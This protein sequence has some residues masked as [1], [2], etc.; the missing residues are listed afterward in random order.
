MTAS[1]NRQIR[2]GRKHL[3]VL[4]GSAAL[5]SP[6]GYL[7]QKDRELFHLKTRLISAQSAGIQK[8]RS[9]FVGSVAKLDALSPLKVLSRGYSMVQHENGQIIRSVKQVTEEERI[10]IS[11]SDGTVTA[12]VLEAKE[13]TE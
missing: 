6:V 11:V 8:K 12:A 3:N 5:K 7:E 2:S 9:R 13:R 10:V 4:A 1:L